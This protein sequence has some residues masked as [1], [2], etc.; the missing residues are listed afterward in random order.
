M[1]AGEPETIVEIGPGTGALTELLLRSTA[2]VH[3]IELD[4]EM[5]SRLRRPGKH[6]RRRQQKSTENRQPLPVVHTALLAIR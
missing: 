3:A 5:V 4:P 1:L 6:Q 2:H